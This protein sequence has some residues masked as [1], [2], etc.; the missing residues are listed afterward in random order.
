MK[1]RAALLLGLA[2]GV[3]AAWTRVLADQR[4]DARGEGLAGNDCSAQLPHTAAA[5]LGVGSTFAANFLGGRG[6][7][8][9]FVD[10][11]R[12]WTL[13]H[14][15][16]LKH[17]IGPPVTGAVED[18]SRPHGTAVLGIVCASSAD[19]SFIGLA[20][21]VASVHVS[22]TTQ[23]LR[24]GIQAA[25]DKLAA[26]NAADPSGG[27]GVLLLEAQ[28]RLV[29]SQGG[30]AHL[31]VE[32]LPELHELVASAV[33][34]GITVIEAAGNGLSTGG[35][36]RGID[37]D[38][39]ADRQGMRTLRRDSARGDS[40]AIIVGAARSQPIEGRHE[41]FYSSNFGSRIDCYA[42]GEDVIAPASTTT[43]PFL[44]S[45]CVKDFGETSAAAAIIAGVALI[46]QGV[47]AAAEPGQRLAPRKLRQILSN[48]A[49]GTGCVAA[50]GEIGVMPDLERILD[51]GVLGV[52][53]VRHSKPRPTVEHG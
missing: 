34:R 27:G 48:T 14:Q 24:S 5:P 9:H 21:Q 19:G 4:D 22:S 20:P 44:T 23:S 7:G 51:A 25:I 16:L 32:A 15:S 39:F 41:R 38:V 26:I 50:K 53:P 31:P 10:V 11:E 42:W 2:A 40:G 36:P 37:L 6:E 1:R 45:G 33:R 3:S 28:A 30:M 35:T 49:L 12:G 43:S 18:A 13:N 52:T 47:V 29:P 17:R 46:V 8:Q